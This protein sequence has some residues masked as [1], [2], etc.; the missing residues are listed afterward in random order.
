VSTATHNENALTLRL[1][2]DVRQA[3]KK[4]AELEN[5]KPRQLAQNILTKY[6]RDAA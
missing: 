5:I 6:V 4:M 2:L 1:D 3:I